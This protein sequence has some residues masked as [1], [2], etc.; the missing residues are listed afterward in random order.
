[1]IAQ[2]ESVVKQCKDYTPIE[3]ISERLI[4]YDKLVNRTRIELVCTEDKTY[5][6]FAEM[7]SEPT[8]NKSDHSIGGGAV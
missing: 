3:R 8:E 7:E 5:V 1:M 6:K 2:A 4:Q